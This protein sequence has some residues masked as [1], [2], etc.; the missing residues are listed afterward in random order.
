MSSSLRCCANNAPA[1]ATIFVQLS[2]RRQAAMPPVLDLLV[3]RRQATTSIRR[4]MA[5]ALPIRTA[6]TMRDCKPWNGVM[7]TTEGPHYTFTIPTH[8]RAFTTSPLSRTTH[9]IFNPQLDEDGNEMKLE[10]TPRAAN[11]CVQ[12]PI[13]TPSVQSN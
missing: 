10:I 7:M 2:V 4:H 13:P 9:T 5:T 12:H 8:Q 11:V 6:S 1:P 3:P